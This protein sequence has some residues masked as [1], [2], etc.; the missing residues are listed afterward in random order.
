MYCIWNEENI[1]HWFSSPNNTFVIEENSHIVAFFSYYCVD[2]QVLNT[3]NIIHA[4][5][6]YYSVS[7]HG[8]M[9]EDIVH[10][11]LYYAIKDGCDI[12]YCLDIMNNTDFLE[13]LKFTPSGKLNYYHTTLATPVKTN[14]IG[15]IA[16]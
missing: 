11:V 15:I 14:N 9:L 10:D 12:F 16:F 8:I 13:L 3:N 4:A 1:L 5:Y 6:L 2:I 7:K